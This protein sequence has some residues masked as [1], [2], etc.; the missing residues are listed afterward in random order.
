MPNYKVIYFNVKALAEPLRFLLAYGGIEFEDLRVSREEWPTL[1]SCRAN[2]LF[3]WQLTH[4]PRS[5]QK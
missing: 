4:S 3:F 5:E 2:S 1:K